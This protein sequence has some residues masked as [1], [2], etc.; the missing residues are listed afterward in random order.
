MARTAAVEAEK[1]FDPRFGPAITR[2]K[3]F[4]VVYLDRIRG[5]G[6]SP[7]PAAHGD[8]NVPYHELG[9]RLAAEVAQVAHGAD[10]M[11]IVSFEKN[12]KT[13]RMEMHSGGVNVAIETG[14]IPG[15]F[16]SLD[17]ISDQLHPL[18]VVA[19]HKG[20]VRKPALQ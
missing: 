3:H 8:G 20:L 6:K 14:V 13:G 17:Q 2:K 19:Y 7:V 1:Q 5:L 4:E 9:G 16:R 18:A 10:A 11:P 15:T 12:N